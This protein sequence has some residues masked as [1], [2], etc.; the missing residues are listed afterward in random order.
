MLKD[1]VKWNFW[2]EEDSSNFCVF[3]MNKFVYVTEFEL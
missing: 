2:T 3:R 1:K